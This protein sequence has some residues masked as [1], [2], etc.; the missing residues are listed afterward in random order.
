[1]ALLTV[2]AIAL[3]A[4]GSS[5]APAPKPSPVIA[6]VGP[7]AITLAQFNVRYQSACVS[8]QQGGGGCGSGVEVG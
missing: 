8:I 7:D 4:C 6:R 5:P 1:M 3:A 2:C